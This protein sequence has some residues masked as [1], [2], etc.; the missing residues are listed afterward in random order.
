MNPFMVSYE[1]FKERY[2]LKK[3]RITKNKTLEYLVCTW[4]KAVNWQSDQEIMAIEKRHL[5]KVF[6]FCFVFWIK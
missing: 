1:N 5:Q 3:N 6:K 2:Y 4:Y